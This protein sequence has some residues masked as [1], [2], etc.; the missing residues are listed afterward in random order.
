ML[1]AAIALSLFLAPAAFAQDAPSSTTYTLS[2]K[3]SDV[4]VVIRND[5][6]A[7]LSR[8]GHDHVIYASTFT[9]TVTWPDADGGACAVDIK[10]PVSGLRVD[11]PG[12]RD[13]AGLDDR[14]VDDGDK[15]KILSNLSGKSQLNADANP[16]VTFHATS[17]S[18]HT[19][20]V[21]VE[22]TM[23]IH[24]TTQPLKVTMDVQ[25]DADSFTASG[26]FDT[27]HTAY[28]FKPF[29]ATALG[30]R[31]QDRLSFAIKVRGTP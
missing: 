27:T 7:T 26:S 23:S 4:Y 13:K 14:T 15:D 12:L 3:G 25:H 20:K 29:A 16:F 2:P 6:S 1:R 31:N 21:V 5:E 10:V 9:G 24:G 8:L 22:G 28:G 30:P 17:C 18:G 19:G 11:P